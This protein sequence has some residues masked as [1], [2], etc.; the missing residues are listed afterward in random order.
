MA[1]RIADDQTQRLCEYGHCHGTGRYLS[2]RSR[3]TV[4]SIVLGGREIQVCETCFDLLRREGLAR[5]KT[6]NLIQD[7]S[8]LVK[9]LPDPDEEDRGSRDRQK[10]ASRIIKERNQL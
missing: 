3:S 6:N 1:A 9:T 7:L 8:G 5:E 2:R 4:R 10:D